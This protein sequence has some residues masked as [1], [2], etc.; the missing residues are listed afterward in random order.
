MPEI[1]TGIYRYLPYGKS[2]G[3]YYCFLNQV[4]WNLYGKFISMGAPNFVVQT[5]V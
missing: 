5:D 2:Q 3:R 4:L 1:F